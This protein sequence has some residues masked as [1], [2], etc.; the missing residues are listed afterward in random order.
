MFKVNTSLYFKNII[1]R[2]TN[3]NFAKSFKKNFMINFEKENLQTNDGGK[4]IV[5]KTTNYSIKDEL[6]E[7][8]EYSQ[9]LQSTNVTSFNSFGKVDRQATLN[10][11]QNLS[12]E[13]KIKS[14]KNFKTLI[15]DTLNAV[16]F[17]NT[18]SIDMLQDFCKIFFR[19]VLNEKEE[20]LSYFLFEYLHNS[21]MYKNVNQ[22]NL[23]VLSKRILNS[24]MILYEFIDRGMK[25]LLTGDISYHLIAKAKPILE[26]YLSKLKNIENEFIELEID[27]EDFYESFFKIDNEFYKNN[28]SQ[29]LVLNLSK[30]LENDGFQSKRLLYYVN[31][32]HTQFFDLFKTQ[33]NRIGNQVVTSEDINN[34]LNA[35]KQEVQQIFNDM[36]NEI[37]KCAIVN[38]L[39]TPFN[40]ILFP[41]LE[42]KLNLF[43]RQL[44]IEELSFEQANDDFVNIFSSMQKIDKAHKL[45][46]N[47]NTILKWHSMLNYAIAETQKSIINNLEFNKKNSEYLKYFIAITPNEISIICLLHVLKLIINNMTIKKDEDYE[48]TYLKVLNKL[49]M[50]E[51]DFKI[52]IPLVQ[53][54]EDLGKIFIAELRN[55][56]IDQNF[57]NQNAR[58]YMKN[59]QINMMNYDISQAE[60]IKIGVFLT[61]LLTR[62]LVYEKD[63]VPLNSRPEPE[64]VLH[65]IARKLD[66]IKFQ[67]FISIDKEFVSKYY[68]DLQKTFSLNIHV[69]KSLPM[70][71]KPMLWRSFKIG[72]YYLRQTQF[73]K[74]I[75]DHHE[76]LSLFEVNNTTKIMKVLDLLGE[77][78]W[79][80]NVKVLDLVEFLWGKGG[81]KAYIPKR[82]NEKIITKEM[83]TTSGNFKEKLELLKESQSNRENHSLRCDFMQKI[84]IARDYANVSQIFYPHNLDYRGRAYPISPHLN[85]LGSDINR[86]ILEYSE[87]RPLGKNG[88][89]WMKIHLANVIGK[90]KLPLDQREKYVEGI[91][92]T[93][94]KC[95]KDPYKNLE[96]LDTD[97]PWQSIAAMMEVS[98]AVLSSNPENYKT[99][100]HVHV[101]GSCNGLQHY[102]ALGRDLKGGFEVNLINR[103]RPGDVYS[104][105]LEFVLEKI[106]NETNPVD[107]KYAE[108]LRKEGIVTR[109]VIKQTVMTSVYGVTLI[110][111]RDQIRKQLKETG[112]Y[113]PQSLF[114][115]SMYLAKMTIES[116]G[117]LFKEANQIKG[118]LTKCALIISNSGNTV[119]WVTPLG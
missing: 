100:L 106:K 23:R 62:N 105:V 4:K 99:G 8:E 11:L 34:I 44:M 57:K 117:D 19:D 71:Y 18:F 16:N 97:N 54:A 115:V 90:D 116:I 56:R 52:E 12:R 82:F 47:K 84:H 36:Y 43:R 22:N 40:G 49:D 72:G 95:A 45:F 42:N 63:I 119:K 37:T 89:R 67:Y 14:E 60:K 109:K 91:I 50:G 69:A 29:N 2:K 21:E 86:G 98:N 80:V 110:G 73:S 30:H 79:K 64:K 7:D 3:L 88:L 17:L 118:W 65:I 35:K 28:S 78:K 31:L 104:K 113:D 85:H 92:D 25:G 58:L 77:V 24:F 112:L 10:E 74:V 51:D 53:F 108:L 66:A 1:L 94:H 70:I 5:F 61:N 26:T 55:T 20:N 9:V 107:V 32:K 38:Q 59:L 46:F 41:H 33:I 81:G 27:P 111:A 13:L 102:S 96:W 39:K 6:S 93:V 15:T 68:Y 103:E 75:P 114:Y 83:I 87:K 48:E 101:D 76:A